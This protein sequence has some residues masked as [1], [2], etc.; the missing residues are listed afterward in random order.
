MTR[1]GR[2]DVSDAREDDDARRGDA[3]DE[4]S[5]LKFLLQQTLTSLNF[6]NQT[7]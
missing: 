7:F 4:E 6:E 1:E 2:T 5:G 3:E